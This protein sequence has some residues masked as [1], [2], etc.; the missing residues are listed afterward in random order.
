MMNQH[1][2]S[3]QLYLP[4][5]PQTPTQRELDSLIQPWITTELGIVSFVM[6]NSQ[7]ILSQVVPG[8]ITFYTD[9]FSHQY[10]IPKRVFLGNYGGHTFTK[11]MK[12][13]PVL[14]QI[15]V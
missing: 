15:L 11:I 3:K 8:G 2:N 1:R 7:F 6:H 5:P 13:L 9:V 12:S 10:A 14:P 4:P